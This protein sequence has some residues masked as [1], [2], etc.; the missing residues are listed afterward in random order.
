MSPELFDVMT[1]V[2]RL[3]KLGRRSAGEGRYCKKW[4]DARSD[5]TLLSSRLIASFCCFC[6]QNSLT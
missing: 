6:H 2:P 1:V 4:R 5:V 3:M